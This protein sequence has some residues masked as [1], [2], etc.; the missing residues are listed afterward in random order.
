MCVVLGYSSLISLQPLQCLANH[1]V[2][3]STLKQTMYNKHL[4]FRVFHLRQKKTERKKQRKEK[5][6]ERN[7]YEILHPNLPVTFISK[8]DTIM[9][10]S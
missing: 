7:P 4:G 3:E 6:K 5:A 9:R 8:E 2:N 10:L 1:C